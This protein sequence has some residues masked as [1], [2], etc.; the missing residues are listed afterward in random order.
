MR[1][2]VLSWDEIAQHN[3]VFLGSAK[4]NSQLLRIPVTWA[5]RVQGGRIVNLQPRPGENTSYEPDDSLVSLFPGLNGKGEIL[6]VESPS[7]TGVWAA[8]QFLTDPGYAKE[9]VA[10]L[11]QPDEN[12]LP[13]HYQVV[14]RSQIAAGVPIR[15]TYVTHRSL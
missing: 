8:A 11:R 5:F 15:I 3:V 13:Q 2:S 10:H 6:I 9:L 1:S 7:T 14:L 4:L 12:R